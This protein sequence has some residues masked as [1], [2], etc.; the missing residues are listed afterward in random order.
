[1]RRSF[2]QSKDFQRYFLTYILLFTGMLMAGVILVAHISQKERNSAAEQQRR[3]Q[4]EKI[5]EVLDSTWESAASI[6]DILNNAVW[7][8]KYKSDTLSLIHI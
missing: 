1:M 8:E 6:G 4:T 2:W 7:V 3:A 5:T